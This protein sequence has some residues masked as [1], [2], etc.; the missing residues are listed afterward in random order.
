MLENTVVTDY[1]YRVGLI[2]TVRQHQTM[3]IMICLIVLLDCF[4]RM[5][6]IEQPFS[7]FLESLSTFQAPNCKKRSALR[8]I[9]DEVLVSHLLISSG[10]F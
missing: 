3:Q 8:G 5:H 6:S 7:C 2:C 1:D 10:P 9:C 4:I